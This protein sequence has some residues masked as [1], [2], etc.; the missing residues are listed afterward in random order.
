[1]KW[2]KVPLAVCLLYA[3]L[4]LAGAQ[5]DALKVQLGA[6][7]DM[8]YQLLGSSHSFPAQNQFFLGDAALA[9]KG[10]YGDHIRLIDENLFEVN[11]PNPNLGFDRL[12]VTYIFSDQFHLSGGQ[13]HTA[14]GHWNRTHNYAA[15][16]QTTIDR[17]FFLKFEDDGGVV[18]SHIVGLT[19]DGLFDLGTTSL[20]YEFNLGNSEN[21]LLTG[22]G[23]GQVAGAELNDNPPGDSTSGKSA[24]GRLVFKPWSDGGLALG[25]ASY[26]NR[27]AAVAAT[28]DMAG[29]PLLFSGLGQV[30]LEGEV[31]YTDDQFDFLSEFYEFDDRISGLPTQ[32]SSNNRAFYVQVDYQVVEDFRPYLRV[33]NLTLDG[34]DPFFQAMQQQDKTLYLVGFRFDAVPK[35]SCLKLEGRLTQEAG[36]PNAIETD[37]QWA[38]GF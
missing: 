14:T 33:E 19:A 27:Y 5:E 34:T 6:F 20:K 32:G 1:M 30:I 9:V 13:D 24:A 12:L 3:G 7:G 25:V 11:G 4:G 28:T 10:Q 22:N 16:L 23:G 8:D 18:P 37:A 21:I 31:I 2:I 36:N 26:W 29:S 15:E 38:F 17:P 35:V